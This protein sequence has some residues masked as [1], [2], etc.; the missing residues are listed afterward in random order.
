M[1]LLGFP[2]VSFGSRGSLKVRSENSRAGV[3]HERHDEVHHP[4]HERQVR[5]QGPAS[6]LVF[7]RQVVHDPIKVVSTLY[8]V[9]QMGVALGCETP[10]R[11]R[12]CDAVGYGTA[13]HSPFGSTRRHDAAIMII[14]FLKRRVW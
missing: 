7:R 5:H 4:T 13:L 9:H 1:H 3:T 12:G 2:R 11:R 14:F 6:E 8:E 10:P